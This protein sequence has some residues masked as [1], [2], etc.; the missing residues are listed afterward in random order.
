MRSRAPSVGTWV[1][2]TTP[3]EKLTKTS[4]GRPMLTV[5]VDEEEAIDIRDRRASP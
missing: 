3:T 5:D 1:N 4:Q 2:P